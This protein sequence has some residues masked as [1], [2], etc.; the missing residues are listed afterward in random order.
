MVSQRPQLQGR[1][2]RWQRA[3]VPG[4][5]YESSGSRSAS[6][7]MVDGVVFALAALVGG[8]AP[9]ATLV[10]IFNAAVRGRAG[11]SLSPWSWR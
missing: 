1:L 3:L 2:A 10:A 5:W 6:D 4:D 8:L 9:G 11:R 7:W